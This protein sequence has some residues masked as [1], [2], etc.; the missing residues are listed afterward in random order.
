MAGDVQLNRHGPARAAAGGAGVES[1]ISRYMDQQDSHQHMQQ[2]DR[3]DE[4]QPRIPRFHALYREAFEE[5]FDMGEFAADPLY[6]FRL[7]ERALHSEIPA[8]RHQA[9]HLQVELESGIES[10]TIRAIDPPEDLNATRRMQILRGE[11]GT[12]PERRTAE[13]ALPTGTIESVG[14][15]LGLYQAAFGRA[16][17]VDEFIENDLYG[18][19][20]LRQIGLS[21]NPE[22]VAAAAPFLDEQGRP[23]RHRRKTAPHLAL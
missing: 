19:A 17:D 7:I 18:R 22:M 6:A 9:A 11:G 23:R 4:G 5:D 13:R 1:R 12:M 16:F 10:I 2:H 14:H 15:L 21:G 3:R 20:V 8:L